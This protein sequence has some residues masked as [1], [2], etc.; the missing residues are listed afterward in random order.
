MSRPKVEAFSGEGGEQ[1]SVLSDLLQLFGSLITNLGKKHTCN[2]LKTS[3]LFY[4]KIV[5][6][7]KKVLKSSDPNSFIMGKIASNHHAKT[8]FI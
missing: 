7:R 1:L 6:D 3:Y 4:F 8:K 5:L 2:I